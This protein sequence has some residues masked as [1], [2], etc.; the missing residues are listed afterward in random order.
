M[1]LLLSTLA[2]AAVLPVIGRDLL[3][4]LRGVLEASHALDMAGASWALA[5]LGAL[6]VLPVTAAAALGA[7][8][9]TLVQTRGLVSAA[10]LA[11][12][13]GKL[14]PAAALKRHPRAGGPGG[15]PPQPAQA[16]PDQRGAVACGGDLPA[17]QASLHQPPACCWRRPDGSRSA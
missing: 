7:V 10:P 17:L 15:V 12:R 6:V 1:A 14:S 9:G 11:P 5:R 13:L 3:R 4:A 8:A 2:A 16:R